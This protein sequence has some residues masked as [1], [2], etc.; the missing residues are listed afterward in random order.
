MKAI[1]FRRRKKSNENNGKYPPD[2]VKRIVHK[3]TTTNSYVIRVNRAEEKRYE[4]AVVCFCGGTTQKGT[5]AGLA[6]AFRRTLHARRKFYRV[7]PVNDFAGT[8]SRSGTVAFVAS[9]RPIRS[10]KSEKLPA[11]GR[12]FKN[13]ENFNT[14]KT[15]IRRPR[16]IYPPPFT[17]VKRD[18]DAIVKF[19]VCVRIKFFLVDCSASRCV[20]VM[21]IGLL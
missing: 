2:R 9:I 6:V 3:N 12:R 11:L 18:E 5:E 1:I 15:G 8:I 13:R 19:L 10:V 20:I 17:Y 7:V 4:V 21:E 16:N 14:R